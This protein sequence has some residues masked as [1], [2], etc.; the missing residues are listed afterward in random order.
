MEDKKL[1]FHVLGLPHTITNKDFIACAYTQKAWKFCKMMGERGHTLYHYGHEKSNPPYAENVTVITD[2][3]WEK[4]YGTHDYK[5]KLF[6]YNTQDEAYQTFYKNAIKE[7]GKRKNKN[8]FILPFWGTG[9]KP[10]CEAHPDL[11][12]VE[13]GIGYAKGHWANWKIFESYAIYHAYC[14]LEAVGTCKQNNYDIVIPNYFD[15][16]EFEFN[17][18]KEDY[19]LFLGRVYDGKGVNIAIQVTEHLGYKLKIAGQIDEK[20]PYRSK[21]FPPHVEFVGYA[22]EEKRKTL[23]KNAKGSFL[24]SQ[25]VEPFGGVQIENLLCGTPTI[26]SDWGAF[27]EN[28]IEGITGYRCRT[29]DDYLKAAISIN[30]GD[31]EYYACREHGEKFSLDAIAPKYEKFFQD[32][33]NVYTNR[34]WYQ[35]KVISNITKVLFFGDTS[36]GAIGIINRDI[37]NTID[38]HYPDVQFDILP[39]TPS[40]NWNTFFTKSWKEY[41]VI[42]VDPS[43][44][45]VW[46]DWCQ[47]RINQEDQLLMKNKLVPVYHSELDIPTKHFQHGWYE[48]FWTTPLGGINN[49]IVEQIKN[50]GEKNVLLPIGINTKKF[51]PFKTI[52]SIKKIGFIGDNPKDDWKLIKRPE[53]FEEICKQANVEPIFISGRT[54]NKEMYEDVDAVICTSVVEGNPMAF[55]ETVACKI[56]FISTNVGIVKEYNNVKTFETIDQAV[57]IINGLNQSSENIENYVDNLYNELL[58]SRD[59]KN[60]IKDY[61]IPHFYNIKNSKDVLNVYE[62]NFDFVEIGTSDFES[63]AIESPNK[64]G[65]LVEPIKYYLDN[66]PN[67]SNQIKANYALSDKNNKVKIFYVKPEDIKKYNLP[68]WVRGCNSINKPHPTIKKLLGD[69]HDNIIKVDTVECITWKKLIKEFNIKSID[70]LKIDTEGHDYIILIEYIKICNSHSNL[71]ANK[72]IFENNSLSNKD[73]VLDLI[74]KFKILGYDSRQIG[75]NYELT[76][77][78]NS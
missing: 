59:W 60:I 36:A 78:S 51:F 26:T 29:F 8:D 28:N 54:Y 27:T 3:I 19:F 50:R 63:L 53:I 9:V 40:D 13:P 11:I 10:I 14:G 38:K 25:Y 42:I 68:D 57:E 1:T 24:A 46:N 32:V 15:L 6:T 30:D 17:D 56:P 37:K 49:Y 4:V 34:G 2:E 39:T 73:E 22:D 75:D 43:I 77:N 23:M 55:L 66:L 31:I 48:D 41:D 62:S 18:K 52:D 16:D 7:I 45:K 20:G 21:Q 72:I 44:S 76:L 35:T 65:L 47:N 61:W 69:N 67:N 70:Y 74:S 64:R 58:P 5:S 71:L 12:T 33:L